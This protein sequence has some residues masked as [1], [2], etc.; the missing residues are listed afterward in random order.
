[1]NKI[2]KKKEKEQRVVEK[3]I[4]MYC[5]AHHHRQSNVNVCQECQELLDYAKQRIEACPFMK[6]K[7]FCSNCTVHCYSDDM[8]ENIRKVMRYA[9]P[10]MIFHAPILALWHLVSSGMPTQK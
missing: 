7:T 9:G 6:E 5:H 1:M 2:E 3:M 8:R 10:R 4:E